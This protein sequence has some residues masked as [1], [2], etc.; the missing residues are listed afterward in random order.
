VC[1]KCR[2]TGAKGGETT[3]CRKCKGQGQVVQ[4]QQIGPGFN[5]QMQVPC[6]QC[7]GRGNTYKHACETCGGAKLISEDKELVAV[8]ERG[9]KGEDDITF[10]RMSEQ[11]ADA[12]LVPGNVVLKLKQEPHKRFKR[13][14]QDLHYDMAITLKEA[15]LGFTKTIQHLDEHQVEVSRTQ[16]TYPGEVVKIANEGFPQHNFPSQ[17][18]QLYVKFTIQFPKKLTEEQKKQVEQ[19]LEK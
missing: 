18:G 17:K 6:D 3:K 12:G 9:M 2:G 4:L 1:R 11:S 10:E 14:G 5:V 15:L 8:I 19:L 13:V 16:V 7:G